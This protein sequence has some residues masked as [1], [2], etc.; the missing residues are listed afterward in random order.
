MNLRWERRCILRQE[1]LNGGAKLLARRRA[2]NRRLAF[3]R[4]GYRQIGLRRQF[5]AKWKRALL[6][7][8]SGGSKRSL[9]EEFSSKSNQSVK[10]IKLTSEESESSE[11]SESELE[12]ESESESEVNIFDTLK[13]PSLGNKEDIIKILEQAKDSL[14]EYLTRD[15]DR[16]VFYMLLSWIESKNRQ[17]AFELLPYFKKRGYNIYEDSAVSKE[18]LDA[19]KRIQQT[20][21]EVLLNDFHVGIEIETCCDNA[22]DLQY[23]NKTTDGSI[24]CKSGQPI[25]FVLDYRYR[26]YYPNKEGIMKEI[27]NI[28]EACSMCASNDD[29]QSTCGIH[30]HLSHPFVT[31]E[32][33]PGFDKY[34]HQYWT[35]YLYEKLKNKYN[36]RENNKYCIQNVCY[37]IDKF[38]KHRQLNLLPSFGYDTVWHFEFRGMG[39]I[40]TLKDISMIDNFIED[41]ATEFMDALQLNFTKL[42]WHVLHSEEDQNISTVIEVLRD[43]KKEGKPI[44]LDEKFFGEDE[45]IL[46]TILYETDMTVN[47]VDTVKEVL[48]QAH[49]LDPYY[50]NDK[51]HW[52][53]PLAFLDYHDSKLAIALIPYF[54]QRGYQIG[55]DKKEYSKEFLNAWEKK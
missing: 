21:G 40:Y 46:N 49:N 4:S 1:Q 12:L 35:A 36:L 26:Q 11:S 32:L 48:E 42:L 29:K 3:L 15:R 6:S 51:N 7:G 43:A 45:T 2:F 28:Y 55:K 19:W 53:S 17:M 18:L 52:D 14:N 27:N 54:R 37:Y 33:Y 24:R 23:F 20:R 22:P 8:G 50:N 39:D 47:D 34:F 5:N 13:Y 16:D 38:H 25:E 44:D 9:P 30:I 31:K 41:L 10:K